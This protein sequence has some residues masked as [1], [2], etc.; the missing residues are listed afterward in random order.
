[1]VAKRGSLRRAFFV[2]AAIVLIVSIVCFDD[3][4]SMKQAIADIVLNDGIAVSVT[5]ELRVAVELAASAQRISTP[6]FVRGYPPNHRPSGATNMF[7][8]LP[9]DSMTPSSYWPLF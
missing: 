3:L 5:D 4:A 9:K 2:S 7:L 8:L 1:M 6:D